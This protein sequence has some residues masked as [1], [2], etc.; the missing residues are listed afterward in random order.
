[1]TLYKGNDCDVKR[2]SSLVMLPDNFSCQTCR[3][4]DFGED[5]SFKGG[6]EMKM[7][8]RLTIVL[9]CLAVTVFWSG[10]AAAGDPDYSGSP[11]DGSGMP[12]LEEVYDYLISGTPETPNASFEEPTAGPGAAMKTTREIYDAIKA[13]RDTD[14]TA[15]NI[16]KSVEIFGVT[17]TYEESGGGSD[18]IPK[19]GQT[20]SYAAGDDGTSQNGAAWPNPR[21]TINGDGTVTDN[22]TGLIWLKNANCWGGTDWTTALSNAAGLANGAC[23][24]TDGSAAGDWRL[25]NR[26]ELKSLVHFGYYDPAVPNTAGTGQGGDGD[27][28]DNLM[29][30]NYYWTSTTY[31]FKTSRAWDVNL[32]YG[33]V[34]S[35]DKTISHYV[36]PVRGGQ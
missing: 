12:T 23:G 21:F 29:T 2:I 19:T 15:G 3:I 8:R 20:T 24:L 10:T 1:R 4:T 18:A 11:A 16:K 9:F 32:G 7:F 13:E 5:D 22:L 33:Y 17:G 35:D 28:F 26:S 27:L 14:L 6:K 30:D 31:A 25:P 36:L 34:N